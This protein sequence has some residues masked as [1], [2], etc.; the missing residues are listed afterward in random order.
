MSSHTLLS[1][2]N[3][4]IALGKHLGALEHQLDKVGAKDD[5]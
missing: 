4:G 2:G 5:P 3:A 1:S